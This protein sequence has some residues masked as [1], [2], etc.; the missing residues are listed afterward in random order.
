[1]YH[2]SYSDNLE[3]KI[4]HVS[5]HCLKTFYELISISEC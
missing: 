2:G 1:M 3:N 4:A 5:F